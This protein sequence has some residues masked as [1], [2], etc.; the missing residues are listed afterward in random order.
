VMA[1]RASFAGRVG[2]LG[3]GE[4]RHPTDHRPTQRLPS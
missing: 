1:I 2:D 3:V 4:N